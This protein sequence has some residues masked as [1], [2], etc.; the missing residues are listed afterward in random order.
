[1]KARD[2]EEI[3][4]NCA[5]PAGSFRNNVEDGASIA[6][7]DIEIEPL[8]IWDLDNGGRWFCPTCKE[9]AAQRFSGDR[10]RVRT[11]R[12]WVE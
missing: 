10:W 9:T 6:S 2:G 3:V 7:H 4:C 11:K 8:M 5:Q 1:M 12:G